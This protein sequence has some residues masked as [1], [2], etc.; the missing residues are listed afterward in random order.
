MR[1][2]SP[3]AYLG[4]NANM[5]QLLQMTYDLRAQV[6][7]QVR[8]DVKRGVS[9]AI[10]GKQELDQYILQCNPKAPRK[11]RD[12]VWYEAAMGRLVHTVLVLRA[13]NGKLRRELGREERR[14]GDEA[15]QGQHGGVRDGEDAEGRGCFGEA[16][17]D[18]G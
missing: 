11:K 3:T 18:N 9:T 8:K 4:A 7:D 14:D 13:E 15:G 16:W 1:F 6:R 17:D 10:V 12:P 2:K 5:Q